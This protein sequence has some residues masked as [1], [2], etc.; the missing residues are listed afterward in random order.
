MVLSLA[1]LLILVGGGVVAFRFWPATASAVADRLPLLGAAR[2]DQAGSIFL[3]V[4][5]MALEVGMPLPEALDRATW[6]APSAELR[7]L[8]GELK[9]AAIAG[10]FRLEDLASPGLL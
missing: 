2:R 8:G 1:P 4:L 3:Q 9:D 10:R 5:G 7:K 6:S